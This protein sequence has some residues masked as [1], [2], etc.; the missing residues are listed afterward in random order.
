MIVEENPKTTLSTPALAPSSP[1]Q[2]VIE[3]PPTILQR[4]KRK[5]NSKQPGGLID[6]FGINDETK[7]PSSSA[8]PSYKKFR[9]DF[10]SNLYDS[11]PG[12]PSPDV[13]F[14][15]DA[16]SGL[17]CSGMDHLSSVQSSLMP[18]SENLGQP[19]P[20]FQGP[21][22]STAEQ[23]LQSKK[24][25]ASSAGDN[26][27]KQGNYIIDSRPKK[28]QTTAEP[29]P[30]RGQRTVVES[31]LAVDVRNESQVDKGKRGAAKNGVDTDSQFLHAMASLKKGKRTED[32]FDREFNNLRISKPQR[33]DVERERRR[34]EELEAFEEMEKDFNVHGN[35]M[36][37]IESDEL[38]RKD[39]GRKQVTLRN[40][41]AV[42]NFKMF[43]V[44]SFEPPSFSGTI[45]PD[46]GRKYHR[47]VPQWWKSPLTKRLTMAKDMVG[48]VA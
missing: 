6:I 31:Q 16:C 38:L 14:N 1:N 36:V 19:Q 25:K 33:V 9:H 24:R 43:K 27:E 28:R 20:L 12:D 8:E 3:P 7:A 32:K 40:E 5:I 45:S 18:P 48:L 34:R 11:Q 26:T 10:E 46:A 15:V 13:D 42:V 41:H 21:S 22:T 35:F 17:S 23:G 29:E 39:G 37:V 2:H 30:V 4:P 44:C 47:G